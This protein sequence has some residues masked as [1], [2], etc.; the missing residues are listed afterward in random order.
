MYNGTVM[1]KWTTLALIFCTGGGFLRAEPA[2]RFPT[3]QI[4]FFEQRIRPLLINHCIKCHGP[5]RQESELRLDSREAILTGGSRG[6]AAP[7]GDLEAGLIIDAVTHRDEDLQMPPGD[8]LAAAQVDDL[9]R[10]VRMGMPWPEKFRLPAN[11][12]PREHW[13]YQPITNPPLPEVTDWSWPR[14]DI[15]RFVAA[16]L[17]E[18]E[19]SPSVEAPRAILIRRI[20]LDVLGI[21]PTPDEVR[22]FLSDPRPDAY[23][24]LVD[25][26]LASPQLG[27]R[28]ARH[29]MDVA[30]YADNK[31]YVFYLNR[32]FGW[33]Y[34]YRDYLIE[35]FNKDLPFDEFVLQQLAADQL[36]LGSEKRPLRA[37]GFI[38]VGAYFTNNTHD[39][40]DDRIDVVTRGLMGITVTCARCHDHKYDP[41]TQQDYYA[42]Y[43][44]IHSS[45]DP[46]V[47]PLY[48]PPPDT[49]TYREF[50]KQLDVKQKTLEDFI[51]GAM[52]R[53]REDGRTRI[54]EY[55]VAAYNQRNNPA[56]DNFMLLTDKG[57]INPRMIRRWLGYLKREAQTPNPV[58]TVWQRYSLIPDDQFK[59]Q[60]TLVFRE[61]SEPGATRV[62][63]HVAR[64]CLQAAPES[65]DQLARWYET[66]LLE[67]KQ[68]WMAL[69]NS[70]DAPADGF[71]DMDL[72]QLRQVLYG[73][74]GPANVPR[75]TTWGFLDLFPD[76][77]TQEEFKKLLGDVETFIRSGEGA[78]PRALVLIENEQPVDP[79]VFIR[80]N[81]FQQGEAVPRR[82][83]EVLSQD[84]GLL[85]E[86]SGRKEMAERIIDP[87]NPLTSRVIVN[88]IW[89][90]YFGTGIVATP[91]DL[92]LRGAPPTHPQLLDYLARRL[93]QRGWSLK[94]LH[95][96]ILLSAAYRQESLDREKMQQLDPENRLLWKMN[97]K[98]LSWEAMRDSL[99][100]VTGQMSLDLGGPSFVLNSNWNGRRSVYGY[101]NRLDVST[102][103][104]TFDFPNPNASSGARSQTTVPPQTLYFLNDA[105]MGEVCRRVMARADVLATPDTRD[106]IELLYQI[107]LARPASGQ[108]L[109]DA[110]AFLG[111]TPGPGAWQRLAHVLLMTNEFVFID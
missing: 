98:R 22:G 55:L 86:G 19:L 97:R 74:N 88:R 105:F 71:A 101:I 90:H 1:Y 84:E 12:D 59:E 89:A 47:P 17:D 8:P 41:F 7:T 49:D 14:T 44:V 15:D 52:T 28:W 46:I 85:Q 54:A 10:W 109:E 92:G 35:A 11:L 32:E 91:N 33:S 50:Q 73:K 70:G 72:E 34:T 107:V 43:G 95:R 103:L 48:E 65:I 110:L 18:K 63:P 38:T 68:Q 27:P 42:L 87:G 77:P 36:E 67:T 53:L 62:N 106:R 60:A 69:A 94:D 96:N 21:P 100:A 45:Y 13:A 104:T 26:V 29:W 76:R 81:P 64:A 30:R 111:E 40:I 58:W 61:L 78:P 16:R 56:T 37:M 2:D 24:H 3:G 25:R 82:F 4:K 9:R 51:Q 20:Y 80:G 102:L 99:V 83:I 31:G 5:Q 66:L 93:I 108:D 57:A 6:T 79:H 75:Q 39:I 23:V